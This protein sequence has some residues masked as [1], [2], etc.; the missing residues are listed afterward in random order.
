MMTFFKNPGRL[1]WR[2]GRD[3][4]VSGDCQRGEFSRFGQAHGGGLAVDRPQLEAG[5]KSAT[6]KDERAEMMAV[7]VPP[8][9]IGKDVH[10]RAGRR[11]LPG[12]G[13]INTRTAARAA[14][15]H[16]GVQELRHEGRGVGCAVVEQPANQR[17]LLGGEGAVF[18]GALRAMI[19][20]SGL[21]DSG[22][23]W[24]VGSLAI[25]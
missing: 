24:Q 13:E 2:V 6:G 9:V 23:E 22:G 20:D 11:P 25:L 8:A 14:R 19:H 16:P 12:N 10:V 15:H 7:V 1:L 21:W 3:V 5:E 18:G 17:V 4:G